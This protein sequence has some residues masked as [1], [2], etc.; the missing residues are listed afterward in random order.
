M[1]PRDGEPAL[2]RGAVAAFAAPIN[3]GPLLASRGYPVIDEAEKHPTLRGTSVIIASPKLLA[4]GTRLP[5]AWGRARTAALRDIRRD[6][7]AYYAF[8]AEASGFPVAAVK[9]S[10]PLSHFPDTAYPA[11]GLKLI[12][13]VKRFLLG[14][15][16]IRRDFA[17]AQWTVG[18]GRIKRRPGWPACFCRMASLTSSCACRTMRPSSIHSSWPGLHL[19]PVFVARQRLGGDHAEPVFRVVGLGKIHAEVGVH[20]AG[21]GKRPFA[22]QVHTAASSNARKATARWTAGS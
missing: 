21:V 1:L 12:E 10:Y 22:H 16:L 19:L 15:N 11:E 8:H 5:A 13:E 4:G 14:E 9:D 20:Q 3:T 17:V 18:R 7:A 2:E 6:S